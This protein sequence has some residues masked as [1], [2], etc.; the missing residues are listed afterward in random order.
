MKTLR[1]APLFKISGLFGLGIAGFHGL[2]SITW[3]LI[4][5]GS[6]GLGT[7]LL[8][9]KRWLH[10]RSEGIATFSIALLM[11]GLGALRFQSIPALPNPD[12][13]E[14]LNCSEQTLC[15]TL[16]TIPKATH[17]GAKAEVRILGNWNGDQWSPLTGLALAYFPHFKPEWQKGDTLQL[18]GQLRTA[19]SNYS[20]YLTY[21]QQKGVYH[22]IFVDEHLHLG[23]KSSWFGFFHSTQ[24]WGNIQLAKILP[25][26]KL[27]GLAQA[28]F[29]GDK[30]KLQ[31]KVR[32]SFA[33]AG[34][35]HVLA[36]SGLHVGMI[37]GFLTLLF[38][39]ITHLPQGKRIRDLLIIVVLLSY[40]LITGASAAVSRAVLMLCTVLIFRIVRARYQMLNL[41]S[42]AALMQMLYS[43]QVVFEVSF[44]LSYAA[45]LGII[46][47][48]P[49]LVPEQNAGWVS[50]I[51]GWLAVSLVASLA[52]APLVFYYFGQF[53]TYFLLTNLLISGLL[54]IIMGLGLVALILA[55]LPGIGSLIGF[56]L[57]KTMTL[58][59][60]ICETVASL[61]HASISF[62]ELEVGGFILLLL[63]VSL[64]LTWILAPRLKFKLP[65][66]HKA[67]RYRVTS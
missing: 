14:G 57:D 18:R 64:A 41:V 59:V 53:P 17:R 8:F 15:V 43:P 3:I 44:Q 2:G 16:T 48:L 65:Q 22:M 49:F 25:Q 66:L 11:L 19:Y 30:G 60:F 38:H 39:P 26:I 12:E 10:R 32:E 23:R 47:L 61:P 35:S 29:L 28:M 40:M 5:G 21:L 63:Q 52:T 37:F 27:L 13:L 62:S 58:L 7:M 24:T 36:I 50:I 4:L 56:L 31:S 20:G 6:V 1:N 34:A 55:G 46:L 45:V 9:D 54:P 42:L 33:T 67:P 51:H